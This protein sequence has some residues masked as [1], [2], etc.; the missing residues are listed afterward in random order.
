MQFLH[1]RTRHIVSLAAL[2]TQAGRCN[3]AGSCIVLAI[4]SLLLL[5]R[6]GL[7]S[8]YSTMSNKSWGGGDIDAGDWLWHKRGEFGKRLQRIMNS[9][10]TLQFN[11]QA[12]QDWPFANPSKSLFS[13]F[14]LLFLNS[15]SSF[16]PFSLSPP[17]HSLVF[18]SFFILLLTG[19]VPK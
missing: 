18:P 13:L 16:T 4:G 14:F 5:Y 11:L 6:K 19:S 1:T 15:P 10:L 3:C 7:L 9:I 17:A 2:I 12:C 8:R